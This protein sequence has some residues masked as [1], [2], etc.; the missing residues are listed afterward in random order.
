MRPPK[1]CS[2][3]PPGRLGRAAALLAA[4]FLLAGC[5]PTPLP[6]SGPVD[7]KTLEVTVKE[8]PRGEVYYHRRK[9]PGV[10]GYLGTA[11]FMGSSIY[12]SWADSEKTQAISGHIR[13]IDPARELVVP[14]VETLRD[15]RVF[16]RIEVRSAGEV[17]SLP[18]EAPVHDAYIEILVDRWGMTYA[19]EGKLSAEVV[20]EGRMRP[21][22]GGEELLWRRRVVETD[23]ARLD[24]EGLATAGPEAQ[25]AIL[26][27]LRAAG[28]DLARDLLGPME[29]QPK[30]QRLIPPPGI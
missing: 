15:A 29:T 19:T 13:S 26:R 9:P 27:T 21:S 7:I 24:A 1:S 20:V 11:A 17:S 14:F 5:A 18:P 10:L 23:G 8:P 4:G 3:T 16:R 28:V 12:R 25:E 6:Y 2:S 22:R 30:G